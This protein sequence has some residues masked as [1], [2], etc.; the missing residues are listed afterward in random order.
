MNS[1][2]TEALY[3]FTCLLRVLSVIMMNLSMFVLDPNKSP[4]FVGSGGTFDPLRWWY[5]SHDPLKILKRKKENVMIIRI[6]I[7]Y[8]VLLCCKSLKFSL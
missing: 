4:S 3:R 6:I 8:F 2:W 5:T 1:F 7:L